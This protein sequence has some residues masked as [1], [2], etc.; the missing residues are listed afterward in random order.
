MQKFKVPV[1]YQMW[2]LAEVE[3][4]SKEALLKNLEEKDF[5]SKMPLPTEPEYVDDSYEIDKESYFYEEL[6]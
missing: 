6:K 3:A 4:E 2:G 5:L 1:L